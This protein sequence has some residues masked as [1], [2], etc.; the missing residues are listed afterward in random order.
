MIMSTFRK[1]IEIDAL[2]HTVWNV[3]ANL[4]DI[5]RFNPN[6]SNSYY[7]TNKH[8][9]IGAARI[10]ELLPAGKVEETVV[11]W[12]EGKEFTLKVE[13]IEKAPPIKNFLAKLELT[14]ISPLRVKVSIQIAY[15]MKMGALGQIMNKLIIQ[16]KLEQSVDDMLKGLKLF[17]EKGM[18]IK[19]NKELSRLLQVA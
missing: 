8:T 10:C 4:G 18:E 9:D 14:E 1:E 15:G 11:D 2:H 16:S 3:V 5:Y 13:P 12:Q 19:D 6:V 17:I 7:C